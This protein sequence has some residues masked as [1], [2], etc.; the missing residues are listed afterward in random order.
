MEV[1]LPPR[2]NQPSGRNLPATEKAREII[3]TLLDDHRD[4]VECSAAQLGRLYAQRPRIT[5]K[6]P[7]VRL[8]PACFLRVQVVQEEAGA[9]PDMFGKS[10][11]KKQ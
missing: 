8:I 1:K 7:F 9:P 11:E 3:R 6:D 10:K 4:S 5:H 2:W